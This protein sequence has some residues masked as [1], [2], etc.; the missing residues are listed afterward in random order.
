MGEPAEPTQKEREERHQFAAAIVESVAADEKMPLPLTTV[1]IAG[2][3]RFFP[4]DEVE[5][6]MFHLAHEVTILLAERKES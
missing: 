6:L 5:N 4:A 1:S 2:K 3:G